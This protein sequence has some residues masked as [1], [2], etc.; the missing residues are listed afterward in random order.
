MRE[1]KKYFEGSWSFER[2][3]FKNND[4]CP[5]GV[6]VGE[7]F[8]VDIDKTE[9]L[10]YKE[11][12]RLFLIDIDKSFKFF[13]HHEYEFHKESVSVTFID[14][15]DAGKHYQTYKINDNN[16]FLSSDH[17]YLCGTDHYN[18]SY[19]LIDETHFELNVTVVGERKNLLIST[20]F[21]RI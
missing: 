9:R 17:T 15:V 14:G 6:A 8:F 16:N 7:A 18:E 4:N 21:T 10:R 13:K 1:L 11:E 2:K 3:I 12:G 20:K 19:K 5:E